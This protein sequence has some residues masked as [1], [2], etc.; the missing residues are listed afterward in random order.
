MT[1]WDFVLSIF[2]DARATEPYQEDISIAE[3][4]LQTAAAAQANGSPPHLVV[5]ALLHDVGHCIPHPALDEH[6]NRYHARLGAEIL[7]PYLPESVTEPVRLHVPAKR[8]LV[9]TDPTYATTLSGAS[10]YTLDLQGGPF[11]VEECQRFESEPFHL[12]ALAL[13]RC[14]EAGKAVGREVARLDHYEN[15]MAKVAR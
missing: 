3:H 13:R 9:A 7:A 12:D 6:G 2:A 8:Y 5:A 15:L 10:A 11:T 4:M 14:D 1:A